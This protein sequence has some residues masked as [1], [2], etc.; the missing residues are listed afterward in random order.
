MRHPKAEQ[1]ATV[2]ATKEREQMIVPRRIRGRARRGGLLAIAGTVVALMAL[3]IVAAPASAEFGLSKF[4]VQFSEEDATPGLPLDN[5][6][7]TQAGSHPF[8]VTSSFVVNYT[9]EE[10]FKW[11]PDAP[12]KNLVLEQIP[13]FIGDVTSLPRCETIEYLQSNP[14]VPQPGCN[15]DSIVGMVGVNIGF[16]PPLLYFNTPVY[17][18]APPPGFVA[19]LA[20]T[21]AGVN[22]VIDVGVKSEGDYNITA[23]SSQTSQVTYIFGAV[24]QLWGVPAD[25]VHDSLR[26]PCMG[27]SL[28]SG[29]PNFAVAA[30]GEKCPSNA[31][32][33]PFLTLP[34]SCSGPLTTSYRASSWLDPETWV[35][36]S[37]VTHDNAEPPNPTGFDGCGK[38]G[39]VPTI[40]S[41]ASTDQADTGSGL[42]FNVD[43]HDEGLKNPVG[44]AQAE[45]KKAEVTLPEGLTINPSI[46]EGL[47]VCT[48]ADL[49]R[50]TLEAAPGEGCPNPSKIGTLH[51]ET[52][53]V[54]EGIDG[55]VFLAQQDDPTTAAPGAENPFDSLVALYLVLKNPTLGVLAKLPLKVEPDPKS[56][57]LVA[58]LENIPQ[59][60]FSHFGFH[61]KEGVRAPLVTPTHCGVYTTEAKF[62]PSSDPTNPRTI[63]SSFEITKGVG[64]GS[65]PPEGIPPFHPKFEAGAI[66]NNAGS[67]SPFN[68][69]LI[70][71]DG[72]QDMTKFSATLPPGELGSLAGVSKCPDSAIAL[73]RSKTGKQEIASPSCPANSLIGHTL[74]GAGVGSALTY[75]KGYVYLGGAYHGD[76]LSVIAI[77]PGV[78]GPFD[79]G[80]IVVQEAL[81]LNPKTAEVEVDGANSDP[82]PHILKGIVLKVR[83]L[84]V[85]V[86]RP[87][88]TLNPTS[89]DESKARSVLFGS[90]LNVLD[91]SDDRPVDLSTRYQA[92]NCLNLGFKPDLKLNLKGGTKRGG[93]PGL[94]ALYT[95][96]TG[97]AN[98]KGLSVRLPRSAFLDQ[99][100]IKTICTRVQFA[101]GG[102]NGEQCPAASKY[103]FVKAYT[104][105]LEEPLEGPVYLRSSNHKLPDLVFALHGLVNIEVGIRIDSQKGGIRATLEEAPDATLSKVIV[106]MQGAKKG[107]IIN[108]KDLCGST[109]KANILATGHNGKQSSSHPAMKPECGGKRKSKRGSR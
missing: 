105:L 46:G 65:C 57:R 95:P 88:F 34:T 85:Y 31:P 36:G 59:V 70:R 82:I 91:P 62:Y 32:L 63:T 81:T 86:D 73:A 97:D 67:F 2:P 47:G 107:L 83:D 25:P 33:K 20:F 8:A 54:N 1:A 56:G 89:C 78:A 16:P 60:P 42:D 11:R 108:S 104:P 3:A 7:A 100:H 39:F 6:P 50:E 92:A 15:V 45:A 48:P 94:T 28:S 109:N 17:N 66:N 40:E 5:P 14:S 41:Q 30:T 52:P 79:A 87:D 44:L 51:L 4:D 37:T 22:T 64:G 43:F 55:S 71:E 21:V 96:R 98:I 80:T 58:T 101:A 90:Y 29:E 12:L 23:T 69:R 103:G 24:F 38:L 68:M 76:P 27:F 18:L 106:H 77:T 61:F 49:K 19:R 93:H 75:V 9:E 102:G 74:A 35:F 72:E 13:G 10:P 26:G 53:L 99:A 84:R